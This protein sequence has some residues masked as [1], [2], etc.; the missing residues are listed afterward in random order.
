MTQ[1]MGNGEGRIET[2]LFADRAAPVR[3]THCAQLGKACIRETRI[4]L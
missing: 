3:I 1:L 2:V 4:E